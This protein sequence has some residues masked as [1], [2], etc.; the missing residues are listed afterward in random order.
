MA[1]LTTFAQNKVANNL[2]GAET[3]TLPTTWYLALFTAAPTDAGGGTEVSGGAYTRLAITNDT[4]NFPTITANPKLNGTNLTFA[5]ASAA[6]G[7][8]V[9]FGL[10]DAST[11]GNLWLWDMLVDPKTVALNDVVAINAGQ[12]AITTD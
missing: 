2:F 5:Q 6:W 4:T 9:A 12:F 11:S 7:T 1:G 8:V 10:F 3:Y